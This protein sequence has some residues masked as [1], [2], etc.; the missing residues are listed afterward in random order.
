MC[1]GGCNSYHMPPFSTSSEWSLQGNSAI[2]HQ[3]MWRLDC[4]QS[5][6]GDAMPIVNASG[7]TIMPDSVRGDVNFIT[8]QELFD[9]YDS[10]CAQYIKDVLKSIP[11]K[12]DSIYAII[13]DEIIVL[14]PSVFSNWRPDYYYSSSNDATMVEQAWPLK[15]YVQPH[16]HYWRNLIVDKK[17]HQLLTVDRLVKRGRHFAVVRIYQS[18]SKHVPWVNCQMFDWTDVRNMQH[19]G[20][21]LAGTFQRWLDAWKSNSTAADAVSNSR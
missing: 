12:F 9:R 4:S 14:S 21:S 15:S 11:L 7:K 17:K 3:V 8:T 13:A 19:V 5:E 10:D 1:L 16:D 20:E 18:E 6:L 2:N